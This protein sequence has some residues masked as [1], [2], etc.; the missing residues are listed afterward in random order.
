MKAVGAKGERTA[1]QILPTTWAQYTKPGEQLKMTS[2]DDAYVI[3]SRIY[4][5]N[6]VRFVDATA[7]RPTHTDVYA[8]WNL[9]FAG[10]RRRHFDIDKCP[11]ITRRAAAQYLTVC[12]E[13]YSDN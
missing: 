2:R 9:G 5:H 7:S 4:A 8:M 10:Y 12:V 13:I 6:Y 3:A 1:W 11:R